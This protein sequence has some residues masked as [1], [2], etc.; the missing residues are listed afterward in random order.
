[1]A[2]QTPFV[3]WSLRTTQSWATWFTPFFLVYGTEAI[4]PTDL[5]QGSP[6]L[7]AYSEHNNQV[8][9]EDSLDQMKKL[10]T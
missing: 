4:L 1:M 3:I 9:C 6:R 8:N 7:R 10:G 5:K 2:Y